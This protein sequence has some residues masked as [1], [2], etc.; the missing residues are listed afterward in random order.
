MRAAP[1]MILMMLVLCTAFSSCDT[2]C[3][4]CTGITADKLICED[5]YQEDG[6][7]EAEVREYEELGGI[8]EDE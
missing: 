5:D 7:Y 8:C 4:K 2:G 6:D 1:Q 3:M